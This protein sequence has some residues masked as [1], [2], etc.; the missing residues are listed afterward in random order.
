MG[1]SKSNDLK[2][3]T[4]CKLRPKIASV[5]GD[6]P[7]PG[8]A[9]IRVCLACQKNGQTTALNN[10]PIDIVKRD[11]RSF[12]EEVYITSDTQINWTTWDVEDADIV[13]SR[14]TDLSAYV[15]TFDVV[16]EL[17]CYLTCPDL[18]VPREHYQVMCRLLKHQGL[19][20]VPR[21]IDDVGY[22]VTNSPDFVCG[23][24][25]EMTPLFG[26]PGLPPHATG[27]FRDGLG[28][29]QKL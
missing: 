20:L 27:T 28:V 5:N 6:L 4:D 15:G 11:I 22:I 8:M 18:K 25:A 7:A 26:V 14:D 3:D 1:N 17:H 24:G 13:L 9:Q 2:I 29:F 21:G 12:L 19:L 10:T 23:Q 16:I